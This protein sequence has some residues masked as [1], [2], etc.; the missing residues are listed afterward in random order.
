MGEC[1][2]GTSEFTTMRKQIFQYLVE[3]HGFNTI[4]I[5]ADYSACLRLNRYVNGAEDTIQKAINELL[6]FAW[7]SEEMKN[8]V[9]WIRDYNLTNKAKIQF[10]GCDMQSIKDDA[11]E[12]KRIIRLNEGNRTV[13]PKFLFD[14]EQLKDTNE[15][16][17]ALQEWTSFYD[18]ES[19]DY[20]DE[21]LNNSVIQMLK[22]KIPGT[23]QNNFRDSCMA[24]NIVE[25]LK[26]NPTSKGIF[27]AHNGHIANINNTKYGN[28]R[29]T[30]GYYLRKSLD[31][32]YLSIAQTTN[33]GF[34]N[35][36]TYKGNTPLFTRCELKKANH[37]S[38]EHQLSKFKVPI[39]IV[40]YNAI[41]KVSKLYYTS[42]G[43]SYGKINEQYTIQR[44]SYL[45]KNMF[46]YVIY[47]ENTK[48]TQMLIILNNEK[49][50]PKH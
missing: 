41:R 33:T 2:H 22:F 30:S 29:I 15:I 9:E 47:F 11:K 17:I 25:Y 35:A 39:L 16:K 46:D 27:I 3:Q 36:F 45:T 28:S 42:I 6:Y 37:Q 12:Q 7:T 31:S 20:K 32:N 40:K 8:F 4:F 44:Y 18:Q 19:M 26:K 34:F 13:L 5:E 50:T 21:F 48:E 24:V 10:V 23:N 38:L 14:E 1:T 43:H 49:F